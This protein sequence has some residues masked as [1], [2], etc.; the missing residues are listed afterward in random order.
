MDWNLPEYFDLHCAECG[1][2]LM[3]VGMK[4]NDDGIG[5]RL[6]IAK[7]HPCNPSEVE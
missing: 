3:I 1:D 7:H 6:E 2:G 4:V 5:L